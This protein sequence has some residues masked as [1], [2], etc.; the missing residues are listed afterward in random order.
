MDV[1]TL[2][3]LFLMLKWMHTLVLLEPWEACPPFAAISLSS[4]LGRLAKLA[5]LVEAIVDLGLVEVKL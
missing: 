4:S 2:S 3:P 5:G 1:S